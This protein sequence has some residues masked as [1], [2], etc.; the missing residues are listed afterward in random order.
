MHRLERVEKMGRLKV[1]YGPERLEEREL[2][3]VSPPP[4]DV[5]SS[6]NNT[7]DNS[8]VSAGTGGSASGT[9]GPPDAAF[10]NRWID[11]YVDRTALQL[12]GD[13]TAELFLLAQ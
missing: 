12:G 6:T 3:S 9:P 1:G 2:F 7:Y 4:G 8:T 5:S 11:Q 10:W 13:A